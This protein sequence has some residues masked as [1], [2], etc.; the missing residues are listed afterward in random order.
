MASAS[1]SERAASVAKAFWLRKGLNVRLARIVKAKRRGDRLYTER[2]AITAAIRAFVDR[3][4]QA[5]GV[6]GPPA[7]ADLVEQIVEA[8]MTLR[9]HAAVRRGT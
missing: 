5:I 4:E 9:S 2:R 1:R 3:E 8:V 6:A 7:P